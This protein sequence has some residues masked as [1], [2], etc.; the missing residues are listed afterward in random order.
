MRSLAE[1]YVVRYREV[2]ARPA[3]RPPPVRAA[4]SRH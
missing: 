4:A 2:L 3:R 1:S